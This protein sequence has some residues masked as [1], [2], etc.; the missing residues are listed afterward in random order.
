MR[1]NTR[2]DAQELRNANTKLQSLGIENKAKNLAEVLS[3]KTEEI[4]EE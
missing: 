3:K 2:L 4:I 1:T